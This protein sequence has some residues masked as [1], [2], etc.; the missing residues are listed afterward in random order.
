MKAAALKATGKAAALKAEVLKAA[1][2]RE[3]AA[4]E[5]DAA[6]KAAPGAPLKVAAEERAAA[7]KPSHSV[8]ARRGHAQSRS[9]L[10]T[11]AN[12]RASKRT[13]KHFFRPLF[14]YIRVRSFH[15]ST[16]RFLS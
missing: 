10:I 3:A 6:L 14:Y 2:G 11:S 7:E 5:A 13:W 4:L 15:Q 12:L 1:A 16:H 9:P 8:P